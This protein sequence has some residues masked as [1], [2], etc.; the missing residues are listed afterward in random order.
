[1]TKYVLFLG[2]VIACVGYLETS[3][4]VSEGDYPF[5]FEE[6]HTEKRARSHIHSSRDRM[7]ANDR[8]ASSIGR[9]G[10]AKFQSAG[11]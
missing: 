3:L 2:H 4:R 5:H 11:I 7:S 10:V 6:D 8:V 9:L 1:M